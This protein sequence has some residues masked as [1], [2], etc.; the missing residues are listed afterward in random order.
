VR[1]RIRCED[2]SAVVEFPMLAVLVVMIA[3]LV[4]QFA[5]VLHTRNTLTDAAVQGAHWAAREGNT[6]A[7]GER[8]AEDLVAQGLGP[9]VPARVSA[10]EDGAGQIRVE[11]A[12]TFPL[13][14][15]LGP[16]GTLVVDGH[17][18]DEESW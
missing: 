18:L 1:E 8:R 3:L 11:V 16:S 6:T 15:L 10:N 12:G 2:G 13:I 9:Q 4:I 17:A 7:D 14:G 5:L